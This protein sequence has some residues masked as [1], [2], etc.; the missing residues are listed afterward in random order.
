MT[1]E[2]P[3]A[4]RKAANGLRDQDDIA[5]ADPVVQSPD[6]VR[7]EVVTTPDV[8]GLPPAASAVV[9]LHGLTLQ[10]CDP[11]GEHYQAVLR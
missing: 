6:E 8:D 5:D 3:E 2:I 9:A 11:Q 4:H 1:I 10:A 7:T